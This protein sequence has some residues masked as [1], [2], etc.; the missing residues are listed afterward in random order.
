MQAEILGV[1][2]GGNQHARS[3]ILSAA[4][5]ESLSSPY[6]ALILVRCTGWIRGQEEVNEPGEMHNNYFYITS[7]MQLLL[8]SDS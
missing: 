2:V 7:C 3:A 5:A 1:S 4:T 6:S 8:L